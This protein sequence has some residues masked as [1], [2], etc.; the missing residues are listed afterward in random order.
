MTKES[1]PA[2]LP[3]VQAMAE[4]RSIQ[5]RDGAGRWQRH[6]TLH[7]DQ[8]PSDYRVEVKTAGQVIFEVINPMIP[9]ES[10]KGECWERA[11]QELLEWAKENKPAQSEIGKY[12]DLIPE[13]DRWAEGDE[14]NLSGQYVPLKGKDFYIDREFSGM[15]KGRRPIT[16]SSKKTATSPEG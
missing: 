9:W 2:F 15:Y 8:D 1:A 14:I 7:F 6:E 11:A 12:R 5:V 16:S 13:E 10:D 3:I 4:G